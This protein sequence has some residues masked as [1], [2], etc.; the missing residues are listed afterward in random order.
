V[1]AAV[2]HE[3]V[4]EDV[5]AGWDNHLE[6]ARENPSFYKL[7]WPPAVAANS[8]AYRML[9]ERLELGAARGRLRMSVEM[10]AR[11]VMAAAP[12]PRCR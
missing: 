11:M 4:A 6:F 7:M 2:V 1:I 8:A 10:A 9:H 12:V 5:R 3:H